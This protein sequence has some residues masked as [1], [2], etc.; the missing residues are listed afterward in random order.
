MCEAEGALLFQRKSCT[1]AEQVAQMSKS[2]DADADQGMMSSWCFLCRTHLIPQQLSE[3]VQDSH[4]ACLPAVHTE[5]QR[6]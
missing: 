6:G 2:Q 3:T 4:G 5:D 1:E